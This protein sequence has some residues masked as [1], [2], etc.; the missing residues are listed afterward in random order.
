MVNDKNIFALTVL[1][2]SPNEIIDAVSKVRDAGYTRYDVHTPYPVHGLEK[3]M[4]LPTTKIG[5]FAFIF[6]LIGVIS[7][8][9]LITWITLYEYPLVI[10]GKPFWSWP[11]FVP[12]SFEITVLFTA[13]LSTIVLIVLYFKF[14]NI[15]HP[16]HDTSYMK[17]VSSDKY[18]I[19]IEATDPIFDFEKT[20]E[21]LESLNPQTLEIIYYNLEELNHKPKVYDL[22][23]IL[24][25]IVI[26]LTSSAVTYFT[27]N[28]LMFMQPFNWMMLQEKIKSQEKSSIF[29]NGI[30]MQKPVTGTVARG[31]MPYPYSGQPAEAEKYLLNPLLPTKEVIERGKSK[32]LTF[33]SPC[34]G[35][36]GHGDSRL[37]GQFPNPPT[38]HSDK[39]RAMKDGGIYHIITEGQNIMP[40]YASQISRED[41][42]AIVHYIRVLQRAHNPKEEDLK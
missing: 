1:F 12:V 33:C 6:G 29:S 9:T 42:W 3:A 15:S 24:L 23:F 22:K 31:F 11:A 10:G 21:F 8:V 40:G 25:L 5:I 17:A 34:H 2:N 16:L 37:R 27:L 4:K 13:V 26:G 36:F 41:R 38:L 32:Y 28:K 35:N 14:P 20:K 30:G 39:M 7:A 19:A 18:G